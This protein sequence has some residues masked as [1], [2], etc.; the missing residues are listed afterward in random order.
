MS[1]RKDGSKPIK[2]KRILQKDKN[3]KM[4]KSLLNEFPS[5]TEINLDV[6]CEQKTRRNFFLKRKNVVL[7]M[8]CY[9][10]AVSYLY[11][12]LKQI[13]KDI[14]ENFNPEARHKL[15]IVRELIKLDIEDKIDLYN[16]LDKSLTVLNDKIREIKRQK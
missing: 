4:D 13:T 8:S 1:L 14:K 12:I 3:I 6:R 11:I 16:R 15:I 5:H 7:E 9:K 2:P 10:Y